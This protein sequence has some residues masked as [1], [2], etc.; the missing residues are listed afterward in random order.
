MG[1]R[2]CWSR[3]VPSVFIQLLLFLTPCTAVQEQLTVFTQELNRLI[4]RTEERDVV[5]VGHGEQYLR[6]LIF[7]ECVCFA[8]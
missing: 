7:Q 3:D 4:N 6:L 5:P 8:G 2:T 1:R